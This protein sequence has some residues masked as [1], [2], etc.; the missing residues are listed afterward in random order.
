MRKGRYVRRDELA[1]HTLRSRRG[2]LRDGPDGGG[3]RH[4]IG[5][6]GF[7]H[8]DDRFGFRFLRHRFGCRRA[9]ANASSGIAGIGIVDHG[10]RNRRRGRKG[11]RGGP[12]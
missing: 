7:N 10:H 11:R 3:F 4:R 12:D 8:V 1:R 6:D 9:R 2:W 5:F